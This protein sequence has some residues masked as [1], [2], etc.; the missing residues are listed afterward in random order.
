MSQPSHYEIDIKRKT[1]YIQNTP[2]NIPTL[3]TEL[4]VINKS[5]QSTKPSINKKMQYEHIKKDRILPFF[6]IRTNLEDYSIK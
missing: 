3:I 5:I 4:L 1:K 2:S 6:T